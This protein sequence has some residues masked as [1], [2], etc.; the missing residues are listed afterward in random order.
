[1]SCPS[2]SGSGPATWQLDM[3]SASRLVRHEMQLGSAAGEKL[4]PPVYSPRDC[5][6]THTHTQS[7]THTH[8]RAL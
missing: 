4:F 2:H 7:H 6:D 5:D 1:M 8:T 3:N